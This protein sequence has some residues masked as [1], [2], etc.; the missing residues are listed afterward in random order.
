MWEQLG[1]LET[2]IIPGC[3]VGVLVGAVGGLQGPLQV[4]PS[5]GVASLSRG[6]DPPCT[7][8]GQG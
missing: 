8:V 2:C 5:A 3:V 4:E 7:G 6:P 1:G